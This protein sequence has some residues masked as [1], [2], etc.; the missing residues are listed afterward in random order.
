MDNIDQN[1]RAS[2]IWRGRVLDGI[3]RLEFLLNYYIAE[4][5]CSDP[6][7]VK[8]MILI[9]LGD[10]RVSLGGKCQM[11]YAISQVKHS[12][13]YNDYVSIRIPD[14][15]KK[16]YSMNS[17]LVWVIEQRNIFAHRIVS[18]DLDISNYNTSTQFVQLKNQY[19]YTVYYKSDFDSLI[20]VIENLRN[21]FDMEKY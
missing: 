12:K 20:S 9:I 11:F 18:Y 14:K 2:I 1:S 15:G 7:R 13:W 17:D 21:R 19:N 8:E 3:S 4:Y 16:P 10:D 5:F 6:E